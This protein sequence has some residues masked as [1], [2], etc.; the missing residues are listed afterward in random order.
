[1]LVGLLAL[2]L[3]GLH[4]SQKRCLNGHFAP[5]SPHSNIGRVLY[6]ITQQPWRQFQTGRLQTIYNI[7]C[8]IASANIR[9]LHI[10]WEMRIY[11]VQYVIIENPSLCT[12]NAQ[13]LSGEPE[14]E[15]HIIAVIPI[16]T[17]RYL[18]FLQIVAYLMAVL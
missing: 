16:L 4:I 2:L 9:F 8:I 1:M 7:V 11:T 14:P 17:I 13:G 3:V 18:S 15:H 10:L 6:I 5:R 12:L